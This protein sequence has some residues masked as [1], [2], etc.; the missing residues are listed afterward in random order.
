M[1]S[2]TALYTAAGLYTSSGP[3]ML[4]DSCRSSCQRNAQRHTMKNRKTPETPYS[5]F[6]IFV[7]RSFYTC[8]LYSPKLYTHSLERSTH[9]AQDQSEPE[10]SGGLCTS[11]VISETPLPPGCRHGCSTWRQRRNRLEEGFA[12]SG[13][14]P[15]ATS[16]WKLRSSHRSC[17]HFFSGVLRTG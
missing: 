6:Q 12:M 8:M 9:V 7:V 13:F 1:A 15:H 14:K 11:L 10:Q 5:L 17:M 4:R 2:P 16:A 3:K